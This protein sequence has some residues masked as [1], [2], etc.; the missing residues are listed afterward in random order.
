MV[1]HVGWWYDHP[2]THPHAHPPPPPHSRAHKA[3]ARTKAGKRDDGHLIQPLY[4]PE[5]V[6]SSN[7]A[8]LTKSKQKPLNYDEAA[9]LGQPTPP[10]GASQVA[11]EREWEWE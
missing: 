11:M 2:P 9:E 3:R 7:K 1:L 4:R 8:Q 6:P 10:Q 5:E